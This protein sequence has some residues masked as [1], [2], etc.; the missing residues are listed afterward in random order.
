[1]VAEVVASAPAVT[2]QEKKMAFLSEADTGLLSD[3]GSA[4]GPVD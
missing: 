1:M 4:P 2:L 3:M